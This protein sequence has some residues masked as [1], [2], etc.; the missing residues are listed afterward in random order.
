MSP[1]LS[2][3]KASRPWGDDLTG[4]IKDACGLD[5]QIFEPNDRRQGLVADFL[6][7]FVTKK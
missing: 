7:V 5:T 3:S 1:G 2:F 6:Q 4:I